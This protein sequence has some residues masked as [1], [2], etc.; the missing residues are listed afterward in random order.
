MALL[1]LEETFKGTM[2]LAQLLVEG[3]EKYRKRFDKAMRDH[4]VQSVTPGSDPFL[5]GLIDEKGR[6]GLTEALGLCVDSFKQRGFYAD[7][8]ED[9]RGAAVRAALGSVVRRGRAGGDRARSE[10]RRAPRR[11]GPAVASLLHPTLDRC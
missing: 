3:H 5:L 10:L 2:L 11:G 1:A 9:A 6:A 7:C 8:Y 4:R